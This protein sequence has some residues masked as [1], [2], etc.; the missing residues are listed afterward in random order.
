MLSIAAADGVTQPFAER[1]YAFTL[2]PKA[3]DVAAE[4]FRHLVLDEEVHRV[5]VLAAAGPHGE[6][7]VGA[8]QVAASTAGVVLGTVARFSPGGRSGRAGPAA[9][10]PGRSGRRGRLVRR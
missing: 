10:R 8:V 1:R 2:A 4:M 3:S 9:R 7:G 5:A 6:A